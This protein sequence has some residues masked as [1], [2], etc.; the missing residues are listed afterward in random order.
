MYLDPTFVQDWDAKK[1]EV[2]FRGYRISQLNSVEL[3]AVVCWQAAE[4]AALRDCLMGVASVGADG[5][6]KTDL[7]VNAP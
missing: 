3:R 1:R 7:S 6:R 2:E 4:L 5:S